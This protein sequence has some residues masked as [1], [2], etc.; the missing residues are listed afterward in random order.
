MY[1]ENRIPLIIS[2]IIGIIVWI[3]TRDIGLGVFT[4]AGVLVS[5]GVVRFFLTQSNGGA[6]TIVKVS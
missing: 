6:S 4:F 3:I 2:I 1:K 5:I